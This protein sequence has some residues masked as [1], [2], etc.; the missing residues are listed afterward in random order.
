MPAFMG[1]GGFSVA[2]PSAGV[3]GSG[4]PPSTMDMSMLQAMMLAMGGMP[5]FGVPSPMAPPAPAPAAAPV[6]ATASVLTSPV[7]APVSATPSKALMAAK[8][9]PEWSPL[10][11]PPA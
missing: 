3:A 6:P 2:M 11:M 7:V 10:A 9:A 8:N 4:L 5:G 1:A